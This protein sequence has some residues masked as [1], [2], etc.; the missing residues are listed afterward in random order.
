MHYCV[1]SKGHWL[2]INID[3]LAVCVN[4]PMF[5]FENM[6]LFSLII[7]IKSKE[8]NCKH[9]IIISENF[10]LLLCWTSS[11]PK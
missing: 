7:W 6:Y 2:T 4:K 8:N 11:E 3:I 10:C 1:R 9:T 5:D